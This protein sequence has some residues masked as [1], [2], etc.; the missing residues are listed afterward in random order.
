MLFIDKRKIFV[1]RYLSNTLL[2][3]H[4]LSSSEDYLNILKFFYL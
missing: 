1:I 3:H 2:K 4:L